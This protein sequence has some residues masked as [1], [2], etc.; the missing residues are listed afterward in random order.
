MALDNFGSG[1]K[2]AF[3]RLAGMSIVDKETVEIII[4]DIQR[5]LLQ[6]DVDAQ[7]VFELSKNI[8]KKVLDA[9]LAPGMTL[10][11]HFIKTLYDEIVS[12]L[13]EEKGEIGLKKQKILLMGLFGSGKTTTAG[14]LA[15]WF[16]TRGLNPG[17]VACD[18]HRAAAQ[19]QLKQV[20]D[21]VG[22]HTYM[23]GK[24][25]VDIAKTALKAKED[26]LIFDSAGR[27]ALNKELAN[28]L[29][30]LSKTIKAD[31]VLLVIPADIGQ[32][33]RKQSEEFAKL[34]GITGLIVTKLDGT[35]KGG[36]ALAATRAAN[37]KVKFICVGEKTE[38][39]EQ[40]DPKRFV[41]KL[42][43]YGDI[44][45]LLEKAKEIGMDKESAKK[46]MEGEFT[47]NE[48]VDQIKQMQKMGSLSKITEMM[49][50]FG[51]LK[52]PKDMLNVQ[53][54]KMVKWEHA[55]KSMTAQEREDPE[56]IKQSRLQRVS[57]GSGVSEHDIK[58]MIKYFKQVKK[59]IKMTKGGKA[60]KRGP[61]AKLAKQ[62]GMGGV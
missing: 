36:G 47:L 41:S 7:L 25:P 14:K 54:E 57:K 52:V 8:K 5:V 58:E 17:L 15:K 51:N 30:E 59:M 6:S 38:D 33:A 49:P 31:E 42:I 39:L 32:A 55:I 27:D 46:L 44:Q 29:K 24:N 4:K 12:F 1:L 35:A 48:F 16:K 53:E 10:K 61:F 45:G 19:K 3:K 20:G 22:V 62:F 18:T 2:N 56:I 9:K 60:F 11:E 43:G 28:E 40:Y 13:G 34:V 23:E 21:K 50:G 26:I 37:A